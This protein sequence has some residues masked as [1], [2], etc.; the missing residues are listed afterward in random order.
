MHPAWRP[1]LSWGLRFPLYSE[2]SALLFLHPSPRTPPYLCSRWPVQLAG[3]TLGR[4][5]SLTGPRPPFHLRAPLE[6]MVLGSRKG[7]RGAFRD[8]PQ[9]E[10]LDP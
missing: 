3:L 2:S 1:V 10:N 5:E 6:R 7:G 9:P 4:Q 8:D